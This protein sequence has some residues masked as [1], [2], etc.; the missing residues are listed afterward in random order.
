MRRTKEAESGE[1][2]SE[3]EQ[4]E[5]ALIFRFEDFSITRIG[6]DYLIEKTSGGISDST[7]STSA[8]GRQKNWALYSSD[9]VF[10]DTGNQHGNRK[11]QWHGSLPSGLYTL[12]TGIPPKIT[13]LA[14][15]RTPGRSFRI[16]FRV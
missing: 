12:E 7:Y 8:V 9:D 1:E 4:P 14:K 13:G 10:I 11:F 6:N 3:V 2:Y 5:T 16:T 15:H